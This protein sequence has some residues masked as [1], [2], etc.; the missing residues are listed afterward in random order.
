MAE[1]GGQRAPCMA[2]QAPR[3]NPAHSQG[4][5]SRVRRRNR[6]A[7]TLSIASPPPLHV[8]A[9]TSKSRRIA[10]NFPVRRARRELATS[11]ARLLGPQRSWTHRDTLRSVAQT[12]PGQREQ[13]TE[14]CALR[15]RCAPQRRRDKLEISSRS[16]RTIR[17]PPRVSRSSPNSHSFLS[18]HSRPPARTRPSRTRP[19]L[20]RLC[21][22][23]PRSPATPLTLVSAA[24]TARSPRARPPQ[25]RRTSLPPP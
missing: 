2:S 15:R 17:K 10:E 20:P 16:S 14:H 5:N 24:R 25:R 12:G 6:Q 11:L 23:A 19:P 9:T 18:L 4:R 1:A 8:D 3:T 13:C 22:A 21:V 7:V